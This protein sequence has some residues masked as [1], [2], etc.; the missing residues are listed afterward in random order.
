MFKNVVVNEYYTTGNDQNV[1]VEISKENAERAC[2]TYD[3]T[4]S[5]SSFRAVPQL[6]EIIKLVRKKRPHW[7]FK[8]I[9]EYGYN[10]NGLQ[11]NGHKD[12]ERVQVYD[13]D[14]HL[15]WIGWG[16][17]N[18]WGDRVYLFDNFRL[19]G[20]RSRGSSNYSSKV[21]TA[22]SR[23]IKTFH[24]KTPKELM[25]DASTTARGSVNHVSMNR[26]GKYHS[27]YRRLAHQVESYI[28]DNWQYV[29]PEL[30]SVAEG[31]DL[32]ELLEIAKRGRAMREAFNDGKGWTILAQ[33][34]GRYITRVDG[35]IATYTDADLPDRLR[36]GLGL[37]KLMEEDEAIDGIG[38]RCSG[39]TFFIMHEETKERSDETV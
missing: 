28:V 11:H 23:I 9:I 25:D 13:G 6:S 35:V 20:A 15:G 17:K 24:S 31:M 4:L 39:N 34:N 22:A 21:E 27:A 12:I 7:M 8:S 30:G 10:L 16:A 18:G 1:L 26:D 14:D 36:M 37:R 5:D 29:Q 38:V 32:P 2:N 3:V 33:S 19:K